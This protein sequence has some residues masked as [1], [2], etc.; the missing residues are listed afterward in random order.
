M[1]GIWPP[2]QAGDIAA[3]AE[4][5]CAAVLTVRERG[6][7]APGDPGHGREQAA[8]IGGG[9]VEA[10]ARAD[11]S[12][13]GPPV[14]AAHL[15]PVTLH[16]L[17]AVAEEPHQVRVRAEAA[18]PDADRVLGGQPYRHERVRNTVDGEGGHW[19]RLRA[20]IGPEQPHPG[21][22]AAATRRGHG[23]LCLSGE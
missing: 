12:G 11:G 6:R 20:G 18:V 13:H 16:V 14:A 7:P 9:R 21:K 8:H 4:V 22:L 2:C 17:A 1:V 23:R 5:A 3:W 15:V 19:Q 10:G